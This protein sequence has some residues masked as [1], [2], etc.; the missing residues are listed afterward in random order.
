MLVTT[1][2]PQQSLIVST[3]WREFQPFL[4]GAILVPV[5]ARP[6]RRFTDGIQALKN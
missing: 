1:V 3:R 5:R 6:F 2:E 4:A